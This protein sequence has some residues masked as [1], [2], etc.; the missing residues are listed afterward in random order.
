MRPSFASA[1]D[2]TEQALRTAVLE[3]P[4]SLV[5]SST[6]AE[7]IHRTALEHAREKIKAFSDGSSI[8]SQMSIQASAIGAAVIVIGTAFTAIT[9][10]M[11]V[12]SDYRLMFDAERQAGIATV[13]QRTNIEESKLSVEEKVIK[14]FLELTQNA[15]FS[16]YLGIHSGEIETQRNAKYHSVLPFYR[17]SEAIGQPV[18]TARPLDE[19]RTAI[20]LF[21]KSALPDALAH[22]ELPFQTDWSIYAFF[23]SIYEGK[24]YLNNRRVPRFIM[25]AMAN[26]L[27]NLQ[28]PIDPATGFPLSLDRCMILCRDVE[29]CLNQLLNPESRPYLH[30][31]DNEENEIL[32][33]M[34]KFE[35][36]TKSLRAAYAE[37]QLHQLNIADITT[38]AHRVLRIMDQGILKLIYKRYNPISRKKEPDSGAAEALANN[39]L[40]LNLLLQRNPNLIG[41]LPKTIPEWIP[42]EAGINKPPQTLIDI[43]II[44]CHLSERERV[45]WLNNISK[46]STNSAIEFTQALKEFYQQFV[47]PIRKVSQRELKTT[48][49]DWKT[50]EVGCLTAKRLMPLITLVIEDFRLPVD[51]PI[52]ADLAKKS[53]VLSGK[54]QVQAINRMA[55]AGGGYYTWAISPFVERTATPLDE[56]PR[57]QYRMTQI[58]KLMDNVGDIVEH[59]RNFLQYPGFQTFLLKCLNKVKEEY[60]ALDKRIA[61]IDT[62]LADNECISRSLQDILRRMAGDLNTSLDAFTLAVANFE[63]I[64]SGPDFID[65][66]RHE[67]STKL[68]TISEQFSLLF[69]EESGIAE[70]L[71]MPVVTPKVV[72]E[73]D[74]LSPVRVSKDIA[75]TCAVLALKKVVEKCYEALS[76]QSRVG[77]KGLLLQELLSFIEDQPN[78]TSKQIKHVIMELT[79]ITAGYRPSWF[80]QAAYGQTRSAKALIAA[81][82]DPTINMVLPLAATIFD[83][84][85]SAQLSDTRIAQQF[86]NL[87]MKNHWDASSEKMWINWLELE[88]ATTDLPSLVQ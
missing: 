48:L 60:E 87:S 62:S 9:Y 35:F 1:T 18:G 61:A 13:T 74:Y 37:E 65:Q 22:I 30:T 71:H 47:I 66:Q 24:N 42:A 15:S 76:Y 51:T 29:L 88:D 44:F 82:K 16:H 38:S 68:N 69:K 11:R 67:L 46:V 3:A 33:F 6:Q 83:Q 86:R 39:I 21:L 50:Q 27:W 14:D 73:A 12:L 72:A 70:L 80:F 26:L 58:T 7:S 49:I 31:I 64:V 53:N 4:R 8:S 52:T 54:Q 56:L 79:R 28:H 17:M 23:E 34:R 85:I 75:D 81:I 20:R 19:Q 45:E 63:R 57:H 25:M 10:Q 59:Y 40:F 5:S 32:S 84:S 36:Y 41:F 43:L 77:H 78:F 2:I 55:Q